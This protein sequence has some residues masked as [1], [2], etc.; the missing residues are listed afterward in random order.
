MNIT[1]GK[2]LKIA[3]IAKKFQLKLII[4][5]GSFANGKNR[6]NSDLDIAP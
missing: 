5:F 6:A 3:K 2:K 1:N 4:I